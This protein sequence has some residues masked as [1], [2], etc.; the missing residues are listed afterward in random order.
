MLMKEGLISKKKKKRKKKKKIERVICG[1]I[2]FL[3]SAFWPEGTSVLCK[4]FLIQNVYHL[5]HK[6]PK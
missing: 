5:L 3:S 6:L 4:E 2:I 1:N